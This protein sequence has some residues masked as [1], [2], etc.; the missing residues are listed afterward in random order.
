[1]RSMM[2]AFL[3]VA[4]LIG[5]SYGQNSQS[6]PDKLYAVVF[7]FVI[8]ESGKL[9][10]FRVSKVIDPQSGSTDAVNLRVPDAYMAAART[11]LMKKS[12]NAT[13]ENGKPKEMFTYFF[14]DPKQP[15]RA[16]IDPKAG[17]Q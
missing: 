6:H 3:C 1:M 15:T 9:Q 13:V 10:S 8:D 14:F 11:Q 12:H 16:D 2:F 17:N 4:L 7:G 5:L